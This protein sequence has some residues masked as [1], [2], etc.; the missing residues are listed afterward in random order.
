M[1]AQ[2]AFLLRR[3]QFLR[4]YQRSLDTYVVEPFRGVDWQMQQMKDLG[5][6]NYGTEQEWLDL[7]ERVRKVPAYLAQALRNIREG[8]AAGNFPDRRMVETDGIRGA[9]SNADYFASRL[10]ELTRGYL[11]HQAYA[12][13]ILAAL[14]PE[15]RSAGEAYA[16]FAKGLLEIFVEKREGNTF[17]FREPFRADH[18]A[19]G[20]KEYDW[21]VANNLR[22]ERRASEL[23]DY[24]A[25]QVARTQE[26]MVRTARSIAEKRGLALP[27]TDAA[28]SRSSVRQVMDLLSRD[29]PKSDSEMFRGYRDKAFQL[30][31]Y[32]RE[33]KMFDVPKDY[34][35]DILETP[36][37]LRESVEASYYPAPPFKKSG[38]GRFYVTPTGGDVGKLK[39]N[40]FH[41][42][43]DLC[44]HEG[45][46]GHDWHYQYMNAH[47][48]AISGVRWLTP[49]AVEDSSSMWEDSVAAE[50]WGLYAEALVAEPQAGAPDGY[51][52]PEERLYQ[53]QGQVLRDARVRL[54]TGLHTGRL[55]FDEAVDY[56]TESVDFLPKACASKADDPVRAASCD[57]ARRAI[58]R[59][60]KWPTQAITYHLGK[61]AILD[62]R[63]AYRKARA[64]RYSAREFHEKF[65]SQGTIPSAYFRDLFLSEAAR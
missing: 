46:P 48:S 9:E 6:G 61:A 53:L 27:W 26:L 64:E 42:M 8:V 40:N 39:E 63:E 24:G 7:V 56:Y 25:E 2:I 65:L 20:E 44:A 57:T 55:T 34:R 51:Y 15:A 36:P 31:A 14:E 52:T 59:Y 41:A 18:Y 4:Y 45:F 35:L 5:E 37:V 60:S 58:Y 29:Y 21:A 32:G 1:K 38:V 50:G 33:K 10:P 13:K 28:S 23:F 54:D 3:A 16:D 30:V 47:S 19:A 49:G 12:E 22:L 11:S 43:A 62:L 17:T